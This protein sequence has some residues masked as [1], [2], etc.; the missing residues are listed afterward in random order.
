[1]SRRLLKQQ[2]EKVAALELSGKSL[3]CSLGVNIF[4]KEY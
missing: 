4:L 3:P 2:E 1:M